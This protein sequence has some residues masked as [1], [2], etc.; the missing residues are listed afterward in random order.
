MK[1]HNNLNSQHTNKGKILIVDDTV[2]SL[3][4]LT[5]TLT[6]AGYTV[7]GITQG[8][9]VLEEARLIQ[10]DLI[11]L[12]II[13]P[14]IDGYEVCQQLKSDANTSN[15]P[16]ICI[17]ALDDVVDKVQAFQVGCVDYISKPFEVA[18]VLARVEN[19]LTIKTLSQQL[20]REI[21][22]RRKSEALAAAATVNKLDYLANMRHEL[23]TPLNA[24]L[25][26][27]QLMMND[28]SLSNEHQEN[29]RIIHDSGQDL[30]GLIEKIL[31]LG[32]IDAG[33]VDLDESNFHL[34][35]LL[36][37]IEERFYIQAKS[38]N[39]DFQ[40]MVYDQVP[41]Y[42]KTDGEKLE[43]CLINLIDNAIKFTTNG[44]VTLRVSLGKEEQENYL[45]FAVEDTGSGIAPDQIPQLFHAFGQKK[46]M[47]KSGE[48]AGFGLAI[49]R[50]FV[51]IMGGKIT[52]ESRLNQGSIFK[53]KIKFTTAQSVAQ[54]TNF[55]RRV[56]GLQS[57]VV[58]YRLLVV[59]D[60]QEN[61]KIFVKLL[62]TIG[63][64]VRQAE[65]AADA[66]A[67]WENWQPH[68]IWMNTD[69]P[70]IDGIAV[71]RQ[72]R[73]CEKSPDKTENSSI[74]NLHTVIIALTHNT[75][76][77]RL[78]EIIAAGCDDF[79][80]HPAPETVIFAKIAEYL[81][82]RYLYEDLSFSINYPG[83]QCYC[84]NNKST[85][86]LMQEL[87]PMPQNWVRQL[88]NAANE[89]NE[90]LMQELITEIS[91]NYVTLADALKDLVKDFRFDIIVRCTQVFLND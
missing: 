20:Q 6:M 64:E 51:E 40:V 69:I 63:F 60:N 71:T 49:T 9:M 8:V 2:A 55:H 54:T 34:Y 68:L 15:I 41:P 65:N 23:L 26:F 17:S 72:I 70:E 35:R 87:T 79:V 37:R 30:L 29:I 5:T 36:N 44:T 39:S 18:E 59:D 84:I 22:E 27:S 82:V 73:A 48:G 89:V 45:E 12:D 42:I 31:I 4:I 24:I 88:Y 16:V 85:S 13:M 58:P 7:W 33:I 28:N 1:T 61:T 91:E 3:Q 47:K 50:N 78:K 11:L 46:T 14:E 75:G 80:D 19:Q 74:K 66:I 53:F 43:T 38:Q 10:P 77:N 25:G 21:A 76:E 57:N 81:N 67:I 83:K 56:I 90:D 32:K 62:Q 52:V 86:Y